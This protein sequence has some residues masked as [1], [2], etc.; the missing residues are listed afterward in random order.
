MK[1]NRWGKALSLLLAAILLLSLAPAARAEMFPDSDEMDMV[2]LALAGTVHMLAKAVD[3]NEKEPNALYQSLLKIDVMNPTQAFIVQLKGNQGYT[4]DQALNA[5]GFYCIPKTIAKA[6][7]SQ[8]SENYAAVSEKVIGHYNVKHGF[9][10]VLVILTYGSHISLSSVDSSSVWSSFLIS[11]EDISAA[12]TEKDIADLGAQYGIEDPDILRYTGESLDTLLSLDKNKHGPGAADILWGDG[13]PSAREIV[14]TVCNSDAH[15]RAL[16]PKL[17][18]QP[19]MDPD[20][21]RRCIDNYLT[22]NYTLDAARFIAEEIVPLLK[23]TGKLDFMDFLRGVTDSD[24]KRFPFPEA[25]YTD[26]GEAGPIKEN[27]T[28]LIVVERQNVN[29][30]PVT[31]VDILMEAML[32][33]AAIPASAEEADYIVRVTVDWNGDK[34]TQGNL[35]VYYANVR[36]GLYEAATEVR[37]RDLGSYTQ[38]LTGYMRVT[39]TVTYLNP[40][41]DLIWSRVR[42]LF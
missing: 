35:E 10:D 24:L 25:A 33:P 41:R 11:A 1:T 19:R 6:H 30:D 28:Y 39:S 32:P 3:E 31:G 36:I 37:V 38:K 8:F 17:A 5:H 21:V 13:M 4:L 34:Y 12:L 27:A 29:A 16:F 9:D 22:Q 15:M 18:G 42:N 26:E 7:N 14:S 20:M 40:Y 2:H 23:G